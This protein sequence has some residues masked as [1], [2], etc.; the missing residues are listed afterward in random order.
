MIHP[1]DWVTERR[2]NEQD[3]IEMQ[4]KFLAERTISLAWMKTLGNEDWS[5]RYTS[6]FGSM[7]AGEIFA[8][9]VAHDNLQIRQL[10]ELRRRHI[11]RITGGMDISYAGD[12]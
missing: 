10:V 12:W 4:A 7:S 9:W 1:Q 6:P 2:Y 11:E 3:F 5:T 8:S